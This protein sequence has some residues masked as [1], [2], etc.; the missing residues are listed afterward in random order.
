VVVNRQR[1]VTVSPGLLGAFL[2][3][4]CE[5]VL[6]RA[7]GV[8]VCLVSDAEIARLNRT[9]RRKMGP[10]DVLSFPAAESNGGSGRVAR[11]SEDAGPP[12]AATFHLGDIAI[13]PA[14]ARRNARRA[15]RSVPAELRVLMLH[16]VLHLAGYDHETDDGEMERRERGL[17]HRLGIG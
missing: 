13:S 10:T 11:T 1:E 12:P 5:L 6:P 8:A 3:R 14:A 15:G 7:A 17:R 16:G 2:T 9:Y 4:A